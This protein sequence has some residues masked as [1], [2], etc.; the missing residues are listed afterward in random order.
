M[1]N[2]KW[3]LICRLNVLDVEWTLF[4]NR[5]P[6]LLILQQTIHLVPSVS[7]HTWIQ[8]LKIS[9]TF[10][11]FYFQMRC[12]SQL[13]SQS[14]NQ[15]S[16]FSQTHKKTERDRETWKKRESDG[17]AL[18]VSR[19]E[20]MLRLQ[21]AS[22]CSQISRQRRRAVW[23]ITTTHTDE[24]CW[25]S[26]I[27]CASVCIGLHISWLHYHHWKQ[28]WPVANEVFFLFIHGVC[29]CKHDYWFNKCFLLRNVVLLYQ[30]YNCSDKVTFHF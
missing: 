17:L 19:I 12:W 1:T 20:S 2:R 27:F 16:T 14:D 9:P 22:S 30:V 29:Q 3:Q 24:E 4:H 10:P 28:S 23:W 21:T 18:G 15:F 6:F 8:V 7:L 25:Y 5:V 26:L 11:S 13:D